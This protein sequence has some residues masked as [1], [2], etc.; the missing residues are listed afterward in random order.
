[1]INAIMKWARTPR[2]PT[3]QARRL[4][5]IGSGAWFPSAKIIKGCG[6]NKLP[7]H[8]YG[9]AV[10]VFR[11]YDEK[12]QNRLRLPTILIGKLP[13]GFYK[14]T[15][16]AGAIGAPLGDHRIC[17]FNSK[18]N[19][20]EHDELLFFVH[21]AAHCLNFL[22]HDRYFLAMHLMLNFRSGVNFSDDEVDLD[23]CTKQDFNQLSAVDWAHEYALQNYQNDETALTLAMNLL[24][25]RDVEFKQRNEEAAAQA[26][27]SLRCF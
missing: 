27:A 8:H 23:Y 1:M 25:L 12:M 18:E 20:T 21:E 15:D 3:F 17:I 19:L 4:Q 26:V 16:D 10:D 2:Q 24:I 5:S 11:W 22:F 6:V 14:M 13:S 9:Y 7:S